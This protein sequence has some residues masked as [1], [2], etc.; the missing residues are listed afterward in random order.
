MKKLDVLNRD[1]FVDNLL[2]VMENISDNKVYNS[3]GVCQ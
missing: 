2:Q 1:E 3:C